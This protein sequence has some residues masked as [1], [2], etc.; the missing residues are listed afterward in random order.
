MHPVISFW[1]SRMGQKRGNCRQPDLQILLAQD[2]GRGCSNPAR[3]SQCWRACWFYPDWKRQS[4]YL[5]P[6]GIWKRST[7]GD[8]LPFACDPTVCRWE[9][10]QWGRCYA[11]RAR[12]HGRFLFLGYSAKEERAEESQVALG[13]FIIIQHL[14]HDCTMHASLNPSEHLVNLRWIPN[15]ELPEDGLETLCR[16]LADILVRMPMPLSLGYVHSSRRMA[17]RGILP[18]GPSRLTSNKWSLW[19]CAS[20]ISFMMDQS[21]TGYTCS[22]SV[23]L[24]CN[25]NSSLDNHLLAMHVA[26]Q[27]AMSVLSKLCLDYG[28]ISYYLYTIQRSQPKR[29]TNKDML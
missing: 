23:S 3:L 15:P 12:A 8:T 17:E 27:P 24:V 28:W 4:E 25:L 11:F 5:V 22:I 19:K 1:W 10:P 20:S 18:T 21:L 29:F 7:G 26:S 14:G 6:D 9:D 2:W 13:P 16:Q